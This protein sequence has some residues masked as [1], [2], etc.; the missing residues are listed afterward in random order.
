MKIIT[1]PYKIRCDLGVC[2][3]FARSAV[4]LDRVG[5]GSR[6]HICESCMRTLY[7]LMQEQLGE[8]ETKKTAEKKAAKK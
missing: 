7:A 5:I 8:T 3:N 2:H 6:I 4:V 1:T